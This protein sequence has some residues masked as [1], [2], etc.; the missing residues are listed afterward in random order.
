MSLDYGEMISHIRKLKSLREDRFESKSCLAY[1]HFYL[2]HLLMRDDWLFFYVDPGEGCSFI[3]LQ[4][5]KMIHPWDIALLTRDLVNVYILF[6]TDRIFY[7]DGGKGVHI[8][9]RNIVQYINQ[10]MEWIGKEWTKK[11]LSMLLYHKVDTLETLC[12]Y[13]L[14]QQ[15]SFYS[16]GESML[17]R[18]L[19]PTTTLIREF[20]ANR[21][22]LSGKD[23]LQYF[24]DNVLPSLLKFSN[25]DTEIFYESTETMY[26]YK[27]NMFQGYP[28]LMNISS[29]YEIF[30][31]IYVCEI[32]SFY[33]FINRYRHIRNLANYLDTYNGTYSSSNEVNSMIGE[34]GNCITGTWFWIMCG[35]KGIFIIPDR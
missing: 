6:W 17:R 12:K 24:M 35:S 28:E 20:A 18:V 2:I 14:C 5:E 26:M 19:T 16:E 34:Y 10:L 3:S 11:V 7:R 13:K 31:G 1:I 22:M 9:D 27:F 15:E 29:L 33:M 4:D 23:M 32:E 21:R 25:S 8:R 30:P